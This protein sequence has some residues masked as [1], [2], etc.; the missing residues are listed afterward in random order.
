[1]FCILFAPIY[2]DQSVIRVENATS[3]EIKQN[4]DG[5]RQAKVQT[6]K[7]KVIELFSPS[8]EMWDQHPYIFVSAS[9]QVRF[10]FPDYDR[11]SD[12]RQPAA[13]SNWRIK[14]V[15]R[16]LDENESEELSLIANE[17]GRVI[18]SSFLE[19]YLPK[20]KFKIEFESM[21]ENKVFFREFVVYQDSIN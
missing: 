1:M 2:F 16:F 14:S 5:G 12:I 20:T 6:F 4:Y 18:S 19:L 17:E 7:S 3:S 11:R 9:K 13:E 8:H 21:A 15:L 10:E